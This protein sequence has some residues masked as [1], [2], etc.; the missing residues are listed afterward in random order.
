MELDTDAL[1]KRL[2]EWNEYQVDLSD[3]EIFAKVVS[4]VTCLRESM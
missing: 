3:P 4:S 1:A 2:D